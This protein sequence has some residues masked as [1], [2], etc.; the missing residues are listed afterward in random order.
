[1]GLRVTMVMP[2]LVPGPLSMVVLMVVVAVVVLVGGHACSFVW[3]QGYWTTCSYYRVKSLQ[4][5]QSQP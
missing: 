5:R 2:V 3:V 4:F 1:M